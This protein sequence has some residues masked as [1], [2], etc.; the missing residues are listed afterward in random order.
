M[1][2]HEYEIGWND[3]RRVRMI[4]WFRSIGVDPSEARS[5]GWVEIDHE[6]F[7]VRWLGFDADRRTVPRVQRVTDLSEIPPFPAL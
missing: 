1:E 6:N 2:R 3:A 5:N 4:D 7:R